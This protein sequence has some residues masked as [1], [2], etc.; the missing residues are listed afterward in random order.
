MGLDMYPAS[1]GCSVGILG[2]GGLKGTDHTLIPFWK[3]KLLVILETP[4]WSI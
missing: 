2:A 1:G 4:I 3:V